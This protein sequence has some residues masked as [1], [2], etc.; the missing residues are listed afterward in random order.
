MSA[1]TYG[2]LTLACP[3]AG[4]LVVASRPRAAGRCP[5]AAPAGSATAAIF[6][7]FLA[8]LGALIALQGQPSVAPRAHVH[9]VGLLRDGRRERARDDPRGPAVGLHDAR[10]PGH[11][12]AHPPLLGRLHGRRPRLLALLRVPELLRLLD[13]AAR[14]RGQLRA[15]HRRLGVR[16]RGLLPAHLLLVPPQD[17]DARGHE[18]V[19][20]QRRR[21]R[22]ASCSARS[23]SSPT[24]ARSN[25]SAP[26]TSRRTSSRAAAGTSPPRASCCSSA[27]SRSPRRSR[28]T[29]GSPTR[30]RDRRR[31]RALI[32]A[33]TMVTAGVYLIARMHVLF[34][35]AP[36]AQDVGAVI[37]ACTLLIAGTIG[38]RHDG[39]QARH[40]V[41][42]DVA[43]RLHDHGR[44]RRR[45]RGGP[46][47]PDDARLLQGAAVHGRRIDHRRDGA[48]SSRSTA[49]AASARRC[50]SRTRASSSA[51]SR[52]PASR[53]SRASSRRTR[54]C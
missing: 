49:W 16:R 24:R 54:S 18:G 43:D 50:R 14:A 34:E 12:D 47:P 1:T 35:L 32:H 46:L 23:S 20:D 52:S 9:A 21:R 2:W 28:C 15:A 48:A 40:R 37:G 13:A 4:M 53:P 44:L 17:G 10:R 39:H 33:A 51:A 27:R 5:R 7:S 6:L 3:L 19:R 42:D 41:L 30:W 25:C 8:A 29:R 26:S 11:L 22:R 31:S 45:L 36:A 38:A